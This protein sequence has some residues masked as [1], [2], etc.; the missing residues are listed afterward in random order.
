MIPTGDQETV[1][2]HGV[3]RSVA[4]IDALPSGPSTEDICHLLGDLSIEEKVLGMYR[5]LYLVG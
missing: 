4:V 2:V 1:A 5:V 3:R